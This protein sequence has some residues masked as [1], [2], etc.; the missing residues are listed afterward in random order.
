MFFTARSRKISVC[1]YPLL[2]NLCDHEKFDIAMSSRYEVNVITNNALIHNIMYTLWNINEVS[3]YNGRTQKRE[4][5]S[6]KRM[7][8][9]MT[10]ISLL[11][12]L[13]Y[14]QCP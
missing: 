2:G 3:S 8:R 4:L 9:M 10:L 7:L 1:H 5:T 13:T 12:D 11:G 14:F 6:L